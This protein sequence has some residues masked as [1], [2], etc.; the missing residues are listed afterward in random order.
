MNVTSTLCRWLGTPAW[1][2]AAM[3]Q[4]RRALAITLWAL[5]TGA[6]AACSNT[7]APTV[8]AEPA[9]EPPSA[10]EAPA[11][12]D[13]TAAASRIVTLTS[14]TADLV[15]TLDGEKLVGMPGSPLFE[16]DPRFADIEVVSQA[17][18]EPDLETIVALEPDLV[19]GALGFHDTALARLEELGVETLSVDVN[20]WDALET[21]TV[22]LAQRTNTDPEPLLTRYE[23]CL[24][25]APESAPNTLVLVSRQPLLSPNQSSWAGDF[26]K[27]FNIPSVTADLQGDSPFEGYIT[28]SE[29]KVLVADPEALLVVETGENLL[30]QLKDDAFWGELAATQREQVY[31]FDYFGLVNPGSLA[32][33]ETVCARLG[34][35][36]Q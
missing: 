24:A 32:S 30:D 17:R 33:I 14:L 3:S 29:E 9:D 18:T 5:S 15:Q 16:G 11:T 21:L 20:S 7:A 26:L 25:Q 2:S 27:Q 4:K 31:V 6:I 12:D 10:P 36:A 22:D 35:L 13:Q 28:L 19:I 8:V 23:A 34:D 1:R